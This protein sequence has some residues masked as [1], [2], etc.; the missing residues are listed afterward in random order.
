MTTF[1]HT[2]INITLPGKWTTY[3]NDLQGFVQTLKVHHWSKGLVPFELYDFQKRYLEHLDSNRFVI[4][5]KFRQGGF[6]TATAMYALWLCMYRLD[7][8]IFFMCKYGREAIRVSEIVNTA[9]KNMDI[10]MR[11]ILSKNNDHQKIFTNTNSRIFFGNWQA[12]CGHA[13]THVIMDEA[14]FMDNA[15]QCWRATFPCIAIGGNAIVLSTQNGLGTWFAKVRQ[16][17]LEGKNSFSVFQSHYKEH[18]EY[19]NEELVRQ[20]RSNMGEK[21]WLRE[22]EQMLI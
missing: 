22:M 20:L 10:H 7:Q 16:D 14:A 11:P 12:A 13:L 21:G 6:T 8:R 15:E 4:A 18:P 5:S 9:I 1:T 17:A 2:P 19:N 3:V